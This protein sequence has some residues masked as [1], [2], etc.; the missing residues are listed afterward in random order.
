MK[1]YVEW[2]V[3]ILQNAV[4]QPSYKIGHHTSHDLTIDCSHFFWLP[5][6]VSLM[7]GVCGNILGSR[8][9]FCKSSKHVIL[10]GAIEYPQNV[11]YPSWEHM[12]STG[13]CDSQLN[14]DI[15]SYWNFIKCQDEWPVTRRSQ[16]SISL[17]PLV[18]KHQVP[19][20]HSVQVYKINGILMFWNKIKPF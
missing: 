2:V 7:Y 20:D 3:S 19:D 17:E 11:K 16:T 10:G 18:S 5:P 15:H 6:S 1:D 14:T 12:C 8:K 4:F 13:T 9:K